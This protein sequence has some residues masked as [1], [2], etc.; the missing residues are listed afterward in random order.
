MDEANKTGRKDNLEL[1][2]RC[3]F[4]KA[5]EVQGRLPETHP[6]KKGTKYLEECWHCR[7]A[8]NYRPCKKE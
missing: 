7:N 5:A 6:M 1:C 4:W 2:R 8:S 3:L